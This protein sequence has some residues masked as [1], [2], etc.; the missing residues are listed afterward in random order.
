MLLSCLLL[1]D[2]SRAA[3]LEMTIERQSIELGLPLTAEVRAIDSEDNLSDID[4]APLQQRFG[5]NIQE[6]TSGISP[7]G[8][9]GKSLQILT[10]ILYPRHTGEQQVPALQL[11]EQSTAAKTIAVLP[12]REPA[13]AITV[14]TQ[15]SSTMVWERQQLII[16]VE[17]TT[18]ER[19]AALH[20]ENARLPGFDSIALPATHHWQTRHDGGR[21]RL[22]I[23][24]ALYPLADGQQSISLPPVKYEVNGVFRRSFHLPPITVQVKALPPYLPPLMPVG[25]VTIE[26]SLD[27]NAP[28]STEKLG[29]WEVTMHSRQVAPKRMPAILRQISS[30][31]DIQFLPV[32]SKR[33]MQADISGLRSETRHRIPFKALS[34]GRLQ[35]PSLRY[36]YFD[37]RSGKLRTVNHTPQRPVV[38]DPAWRLLIIACLLYLAYRM[39]R[40]LLAHAQRGWRKRRLQQR[41]MKQ[42]AQARTADELR[43]A[44]LTLGSAQGW[45][46]NLNVSQWMQ[47]WCARFHTSPALVEAASELSTACYAGSPRTDITELRQRLLRE[48]ATPT[49]KRT[50]PGSAEADP[51][52]PDSFNHTA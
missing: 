11:G 26:S 21:S 43:R 13:G 19:F 31:Q 27:Q 15:V 10:L 33:S 16:S 41:A 38:L 50:K 44:L 3:V 35:L 47:H 4:L 48:L 45:P 28:V 39:T 36:Q 46:G 42:L 7:A 5:V 29:Y 2:V 51:W 6:Y 32:D 8:H 49:P 14:R 9:A 30:N 18:P 24:W 37:P 34:N 22:R 1:F 23:G 17:V 40:G 52:L 25:K 20:S 12:A